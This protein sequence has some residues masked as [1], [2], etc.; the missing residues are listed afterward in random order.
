VVWL[1]SLLLLH[2]SLRDDR[3]RSRIPIATHGFEQRDS[4]IKAS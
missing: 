4:G 2:R 3:L 1:A